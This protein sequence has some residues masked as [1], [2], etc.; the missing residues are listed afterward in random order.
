MQSVDMI[1]RFE[2]P[3]EVDKDE[4]RQLTRRL[5]FELEDVGVESIA[6]LRSEVIVPGGKGAD[7]ITWGA[8]TV[9]VV[10]TMLPKVLEFLQAWALRNQEHVVK[11]KVQLDNHSVEVEYPVKMKPEE[12]KSHVAA[13]TTMLIE[14]KKDS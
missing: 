7:L 3:E 14:D 10:Q 13:V 8:L 5:M 6:P 9:V 11:I 1:I 2:V 12:L 4:Q